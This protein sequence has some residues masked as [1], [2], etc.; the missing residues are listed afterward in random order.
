M[1]IWRKNKEDGP[2]QNLTDNQVFAGVALW[3]NTDWKFH[4][5]YQAYISNVCVCM[6]ERKKKADGQ[7]ENKLCSF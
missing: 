2:I 3:E 7:L 5:S 6:W 4:L 1:E